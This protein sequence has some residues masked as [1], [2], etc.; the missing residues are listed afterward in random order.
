MLRRRLALEGVPRAVP[1]HPALDVRLRGAGR[2]TETPGSQ[3]KDTALRWLELLAMSRRTTAQSTLRE[4]S[5]H[6]AP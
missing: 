5:E 1:M 4:A 3:R 6:R 2:R